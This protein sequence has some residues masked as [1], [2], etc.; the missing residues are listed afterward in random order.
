MEQ[1]TPKTIKTRVCVVLKSCFIKSVMHKTQGGRNKVLHHRNTSAFLSQSLWWM[2]HSDHWQAQRTK[3]YTHAHSNTLTRDNAASA[4]KSRLWLLV[5]GQEMFCFQKSVRPSCAK[6]SAHNAERAGCSA[7]HGGLSTRPIHAAYM[8]VMQTALRVLCTWFNSS[9]L[10][11]SVWG[12]ERQQGA[13]LPAE[14]IL[15]T[16]TSCWGTEFS[17][18]LWQGIRFSRNFLLLHL[19]FAFT[20]YYCHK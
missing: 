5:Y 15:K 8:R 12:S 14:A 10:S 11:L 7:D 9:S 2:N 13:A 17:F 18:S 20:S 6:N 19:F 4:Q 3:S 16:S 1:E